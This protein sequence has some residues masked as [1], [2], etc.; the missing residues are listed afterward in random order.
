[1]KTIIISTFLLVALVTGAK[2][3]TDAQQ[4]KMNDAMMAENMKAINKS[5]ATNNRT[6]N[7]SRS[8]NV[9]MKEGK[10]YTE[11]NGKQQRMT[12]NV[13]M[14]NG[15]DVL[16][17]GLVNKPDGSQMGM[18]NGMFIDMYGNISY[19]PKSKN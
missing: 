1:M 15:T 2:A 14:R 13:K 9:L 11:K 10:L 4:D 6:W 17:N 12:R 7:E 18:R 3:Q 8:S 5:S 16:T 19:R